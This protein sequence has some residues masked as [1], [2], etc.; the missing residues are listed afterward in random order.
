MS[1]NCVFIARV[2][3]GKP[4]HKRDAQHTTRF[5]H[6]NACD[7]AV[8][9]VSAEPLLGPIDMREESV[10]WVIVGGESGPGARPM[11]IDWAR[12]LVSQC[13]ATGIPCFVKQL[14]AN[15]RVGPFQLAHNSRKGNDPSEWPDDL[16]VRQWPVRG[17]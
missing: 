1:A 10:D 7:A 4:D 14:G 13:A 17:S 15:A 16:Q 8:K 9:F 3:T 2:K 6:A 11:V 12:T 5:H